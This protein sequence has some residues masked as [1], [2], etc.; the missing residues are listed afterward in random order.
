M[1]PFGPTVLTSFF[2]SLVCLPSLA[3][4]PKVRLFRDWLLEEAEASGARPPPEGLPS[5]P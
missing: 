4:Q 1:Q 5:S 3:E 2:Y